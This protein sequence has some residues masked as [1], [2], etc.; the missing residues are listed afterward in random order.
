MHVSTPTSSAFSATSSSPIY[1]TPVSSKN[2]AHRWS[3]SVP[4]QLVFNHGTPLIL[5][6][7]KQQL[8]LSRHFQTHWQRNTGTTVPSH[9]TI[10]GERLWDGPQGCWIALTTTSPG[11]AS[12]RLSIMHSNTAALHWKTRW[13]TSISRRATGGQLQI[14]GNGSKLWVLSTGTPAAGMMPKL[15][16]SSPNGGGSWSLIAAGNVLSMPAP[17]RL[18]AGYPT[19]ITAIS[20]NHLIL[21]LEASNTS[22][23]AVSYTFHP[24]AVH[25]LPFPAPLNIQWTISLPALVDGSTVTIPIMGL[26]HGAKSVLR[27]ATRKSSHSVWTLH[28]IAAL[29]GGSA[30]TESGNMDVLSG[31]THLDVVWP[32]G[33]VV[34]L[35]E[36]K[37]FPNPLVTAQM[38]SH[39]VVLGKDKSLWVNSH[40]GWR[41]WS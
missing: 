32:T 38:G 1:T 16:W 15:L 12:A 30:T 40:E 6:S 24:R 13:S 11:D 41:K 35:P 21:T 10:N 29:P 27:I 5:T 39:I 19:G 7:T 37:S 14:T 20:R 36:L 17:L 4:P 18:P 2:V 22:M 28:P 26:S 25:I 31:I 8:V 34:Q 23:T 9:H 3:T 33:H